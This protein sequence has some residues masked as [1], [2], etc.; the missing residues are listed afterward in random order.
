MSQA[1]ECTHLPNSSTSKLACLNNCL[2]SYV[3]EVHKLK[4]EN[5][6]YSS[7]VEALKQQLE[8]YN[9]DGIRERF[10]AK[11]SQACS[12]TEEAEK[13]KAKYQLV[14]EKNTSRIGELENE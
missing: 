12:R 8:D 11:W 9:C 14:A 7:E 4:N 13:D 10:E 5:L 6:R 2:A 1:S 3:E